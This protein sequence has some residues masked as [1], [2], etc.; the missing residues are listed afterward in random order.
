[1][2][3]ARAFGDSVG[4]FE[5]RV[6]SV[7]EKVEAEMRLLRGT[8]QKVVGRLES[9]AEDNSREREE[10]AKVVRGVEGLDKRMKTMEEK[11]DWICRAL[12]AQGR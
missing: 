10:M 5:Q 9:E 12:A 11:I 1:M 3:V 2:E 8:L 7:E 4:A 6:I